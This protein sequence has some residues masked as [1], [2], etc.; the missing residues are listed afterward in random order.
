MPAGIAFL[1]LAAMPLDDRKGPENTG[2]HILGIERLPFEPLPQ[3]IGNVEPR[4]GA[5]PR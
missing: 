4:E 3:R 2:G 1:Q 5:I